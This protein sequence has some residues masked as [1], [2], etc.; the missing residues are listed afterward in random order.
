M[1]Q[2]SL[3]SFSLS[4]PG[5]YITHS[6]TWLGDWGVLCQQRLMQH[7]ASSL[8]QSYRCLISSLLSN[9]T[10]SDSFTFIQTELMLTQVTSLEDIYQTSHSSLWRHLRLDTTNLPSRWAED[11]RT[12]APSCPV[13]FP[14][15]QPTSRA[16]LP[17]SPTFRWSSC[18]SSRAAQST[19]PESRSPS[20]LVLPIG[21]ACWS[22]S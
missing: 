4:K 3:Y 7:G 12:P 6:A 2:N 5:A 21:P 11:F 13:A 8:Q 1:Q 9:S 19:L 10:P 14:D 15:L 20:N 18:L 17:T 22:P 16:V